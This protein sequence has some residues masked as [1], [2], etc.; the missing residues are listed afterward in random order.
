MQ[1]AGRLGATDEQQLVYAASQHLA[2]LTHNRADCVS[3]HDINF[4]SVVAF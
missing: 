1:E 3:L 4:A 2:L